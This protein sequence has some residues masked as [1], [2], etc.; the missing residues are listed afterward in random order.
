MFS[1][2]QD[3]DFFFEILMRIF[4]EIYLDTDLNREFYI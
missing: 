1:V 3:E 2:E 4:I